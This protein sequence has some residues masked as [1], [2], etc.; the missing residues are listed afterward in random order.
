MEGTLCM[1]RENSFLAA[2]FLI[3]LVLGF[4]QVNV[5]YFQKKK[6]IKSIRNVSHVEKTG[7]GEAKKRRNRE[8]GPI[9]P[10]PLFQ[11]SAFPLLI[12]QEAR[13]YELQGAWTSVSGLVPQLGRIGSVWD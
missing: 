7:G 1:R 11:R 9:W 4:G 5:A 12:W 8:I 2:L 10:G 6:A 3:V 13:F